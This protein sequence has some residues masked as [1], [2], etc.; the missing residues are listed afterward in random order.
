MEY[1]K[2]KMTYEKTNPKV[3]KLSYLMNVV[4]VKVLLQGV[5]FSKFFASYIFYFSMDLGPESFDLPFPFWSVLL[6]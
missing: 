2:S 5:M 4:I 1:P 3:E 6:I